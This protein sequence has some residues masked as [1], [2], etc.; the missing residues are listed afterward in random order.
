MVVNL[1][2][3]G[4]TT[5]AFLQLGN[6]VNLLLVQITIQLFF[7]NIGEGNLIELIGALRHAGTAVHALHHG[8][9]EACPGDV[10]VFSSS[11]TEPAVTLQAQAGAEHP[12][13]CL[14][15]ALNE[16]VIT[17][18]LSDSPIFLELFTRVANLLRIRIEEVQR[19]AIGI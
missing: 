16:E 19:G 8:S 5:V 18:N 1:L 14:H 12:L 10:L 15:S 6:K 11:G 9:D 3:D 13:L 17:E 4:K 7:Q 2:L